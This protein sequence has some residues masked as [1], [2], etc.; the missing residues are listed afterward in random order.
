MDIYKAIQELRNEKERL[1][2]TI[3]ALEKGLG[4]TDRRPERRAWN[5]DARRAA[6]ARM[7]KYWEQRKQQG[8]AK[9]AAAG[10]S[11]SPPSTEMV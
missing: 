2:R 8:S 7:K 4:K 6:A 11:A 5:A 3:E 9:A 10:Y 1:D